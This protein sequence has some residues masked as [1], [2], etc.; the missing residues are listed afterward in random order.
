MSAEPRAAE[1]TQDEGDAV[2]N[3]TGGC[4]LIGWICSTPFWLIN[5][6]AGI[7]AWFVL[8]VIVSSMIGR[9]T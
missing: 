5:T 8:A 7:A 9:P 3:R 1:H 4:L 6:A 2:K